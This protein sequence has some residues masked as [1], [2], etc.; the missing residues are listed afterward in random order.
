M[1]ERWQGARGNGADEP[2]RDMELAGALEALDPAIG[3]PNYWLRFRH[4][5]LRNAA[6]ELARR[7]LMAELT[8]GEV[9]TSWAR[10]VV[11]TAVLAA[12]LA[13]ILLVRGEMSSSQAPVSVE[14]LLEAEF[15]GLTIPADL[16]L[17]EPGAA[18]AFAEETY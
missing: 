4:W 11:P 6:P 2:V 10:A 13:G 12:A 9:M 18:V 15:E 16:T 8:V 7:R 14:V 3:D 17:P 1:S 5:V